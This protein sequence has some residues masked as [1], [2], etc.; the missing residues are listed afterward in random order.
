MLF[1]SIQFLIF[2]FIVTVLYFA[3]PHKVRWIWLLLTSYYFYMSWNPKYFVIIATSTLITYSSGF[4]IDKANRIHD[5]KRSVNLKRLWVFLS[6]LSNLGI[7]VFFKYFNFFANSLVRVFSHLDISVHI[8]VVDYLLPVGISFYTFQAL[9]YTID[10][11]RKDVKIEKNLGK[12]ALYVSFFPQLLAGPIGKSKYMLHQYNEKHSFDYERIKNGLLLMLWGLIQK[13]V[14]ADRLAILVNTVY[15]SPDNYKGLEIV[16]A[17][18]FYAFQIYCDFS[19]YSD[20]AIGAGEVLGYR[21]PKNFERPYFS[22][23]IKEFWRRWH[24]TLGAWFKDYL[25]FPLGGNRCSKV[26]NYYNIIVVFIVCGLWHGATINFIIWGALHGIYQVTGEML[27]PFKNSMMKVLNINPKGFSI[28]LFQVLVTFVLVDFAWIFFKAGTFTIA[29]TLIKKMF[30]FNPGIFSNGSIYKLGLAPMDFAIAI[31]SVGLILVVNM[32]QRT[33]N[34]RSKLA[35][36]KMLLRW[37]VYLS[38]VLIILIF[39]IYGPGY[40]AQ[41]FIYLQF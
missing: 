25:Y 23:S 34:L 8:P 9:S 12:Y 31:L 13:L 17:T 2:F 4:L 26:R 14:I 29:I 32:M 22:K 27:K 36:Q 20:M 18:V 41:Q 10:V 1:S 39:G 15:K 21:L 5:E 16:I 37:F 6:L 35:K 28:K 11:Y 7:L 30:Y 38:A 3:I 40:N 24:I 19:A 33:R